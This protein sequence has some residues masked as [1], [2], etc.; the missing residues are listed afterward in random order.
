MTIVHEIAPHVFVRWPSGQPVRKTCA[1]ETVIVRR[2][3]GSQNQADRS[4]EPYEAELHL[5]AVIA[6]AWS[7]DE[8]AAMRLYRVEAFA[9]PEGKR[10]TG[11]ARYERNDDGSVVELYDVEDI[12]PPAVP[13]QKAERFLHALGF[14]SAAEAIAALGA[15]A[16]S[17]AKVEERA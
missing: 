16:D 12:P 7:D 1:T 13:E 2:E 15:L 17:E 11:A 6:D 5:P 14:G 10:A 8:L 4:C 9:V 3:D